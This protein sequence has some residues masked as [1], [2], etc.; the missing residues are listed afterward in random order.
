MKVSP[1]SLTVMLPFRFVTVDANAQ[2]VVVTDASKQ[3][4]VLHQHRSCGLK[5]AEIIICSP[6]DLSL[7]RSQ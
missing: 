2:G 4:A 1:E 7:V 6:E 5:H 3:M